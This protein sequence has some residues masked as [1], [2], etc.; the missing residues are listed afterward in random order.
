MARP[1][2]N[3]NQVPTETR[4]LDAAERAFGELGYVGARLEDI[5]READIRRPSLLYH[6]KSK[7]KLYEKV[8][9]RVLDALREQLA[10]EMRPAP[11]IE[12]VENLTSSFINFVDK[13]PA[14]A[15]IILREI[16]DGRGPAREIFIKEIVP[17]LGFV[18]VW[19][20]SQGK[21]IVSDDISIRAGLVQICSSVL[22]RSSSGP[23]KIPFW[24]DKDYTL[25]L[26]RQI[27]LGQV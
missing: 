19:L 24:G 16:I 7:D 23:L 17:V 22:L 21:G 11:F 10:A 14:F 6:Y 15:P 2:K 20:R 25:I 12:Q 5:A 13:R 9:I 26:A 27:F 3:A 1:K 4:I 8:V 18:E